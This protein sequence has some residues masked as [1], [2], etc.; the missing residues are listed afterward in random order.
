MAKIRHIRLRGE[1]TITPYGNL[2]FDDL[3]YLKNR[4]AI[5]AT[6]AQ[7]L[8]LP[9]LLDGENFPAPEEQQLK[10]MP[11]QETTFI[12]AGDEIKAPTKPPEAPTKNPSFSEDDYW[13]VIEAAAKEKTNS[14]GYAA[15]DTVLHMLRQREMP[16]ISGTQ[17]RKITDG[18]KPAVTSNP[19]STQT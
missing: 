12:R 15:T 8:A 5:K 2:E 14:Q 17:I 1:Q 11:P 10:K 19:A 16:P 18:K 4:D 3:G 6:D 7:L 13:A 9:N